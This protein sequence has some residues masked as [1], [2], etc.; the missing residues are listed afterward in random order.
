[1]PAS[2]M[3]LGGIMMLTTVSAALLTYSTESLATL[4][5]VVILISVI[6]VSA[7]F[8][9][10]Q[11]TWSEAIGL[12]LLILLSLSIGSFVGSLLS[13]TLYSILVSF[14][15]LVVLLIYSISITMVYKR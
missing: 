5:G 15:I 1:M 12:F 9:D 11:L 2:G 8:V 7:R 4:L 14:S 10:K 6:L 13:R 3:K